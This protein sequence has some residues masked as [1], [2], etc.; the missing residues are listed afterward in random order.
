MGKKKLPYLVGLVVSTTVYHSSSHSPHPKKE[1][2]KTLPPHPYWKIRTLLPSN[3][4]LLQLKASVKRD[5]IHS[6]SSVPPSSF[7]TSGPPARP[8]ARPPTR[9]PAPSLFFHTLVIRVLILSCPACLRR[10]PCSICHIQRRCL[11]ACLLS[12]ACCNLFTT[13]PRCQSFSLCFPKHH[14]PP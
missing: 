6:T 5:V 8:P 1:T 2:T 3:F 13:H 11:P 10:V 14:P 9:S 7:P 12:P 4:F